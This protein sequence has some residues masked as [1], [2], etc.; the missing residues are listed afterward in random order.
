MTTYSLGVPGPVIW[1]W[2]ILVGLVLLYVGYNL[3]NDRPI[4]TALIYAFLIVGPAAI[5]YHSYLYY[6]NS[7]S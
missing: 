3:L 5:V 7:R 2:H 6:A 1:I 4:P